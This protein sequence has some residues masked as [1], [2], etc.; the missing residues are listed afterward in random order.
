MFTAK[1]TAKLL[2][3]TLHAQPY[4]SPILYAM[5]NAQLLLMASFPMPWNKPGCSI[6][7]QQNSIPVVFSLSEGQTVAGFARHWRN[8]IHLL[9]SS[10]INFYSETQVTLSA[11]IALS[12][13]TRA[14]TQAVSSS[15]PKLKH[16]SKKSTIYK[17]A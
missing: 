6:A 8:R 9:Q 11:C 17:Q 15:M 12:P 3:H 14:S 16:Y 7:V 10:E 5:A 2:L 1:R 13:G 4:Q